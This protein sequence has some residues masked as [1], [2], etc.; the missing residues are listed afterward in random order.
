MLITPMQALLALRSGWP[1]A[2][3]WSFLCMQG[4]DY[5]STSTASSSRASRIKLAD[6]DPVE[7]G[8]GPSTAP[9]APGGRPASPSGA[10]A[11]PAVIERRLF[12]PQV[13]VPCMQSAPTACWGK[14]SHGCVPACSD[15]LPALTQPSAALRW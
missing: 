11:A 3:T 6:P 15:T 4:E 7:P 8:Q 10:A 9:A 5:A 1:G 14:A 2:D 12:E 13:G